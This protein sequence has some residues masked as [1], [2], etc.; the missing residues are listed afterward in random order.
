M[1]AVHLLLGLIGANMLIILFALGLSAL[2]GAY[3]WPY[4][5]NEWLM[6]AGRPA[7]V[8]PWHGALIGLVPGFGQASLPVAAI[9]WIAMLFLVGS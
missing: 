3:A 6:F 9:T 8:E 7:T 4:A 1:K 5:I 2:I